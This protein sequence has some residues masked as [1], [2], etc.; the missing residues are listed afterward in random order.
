MPTSPPPTSTPGPTPTPSP[1]P[2]PPSFTLKE[3]TYGAAGTL[4][5]W[6]ILKDNGA[7]AYD[8][9]HWKDT[10]ELRYPY[11]FKA[12]GTV[13]IVKAKWKIENPVEDAT[14]KVEGTGPDGMKF[15]K[16][17]L[18]ASNEEEIEIT[19]VDASQALG[20]AVRFYDTFDISWKISVNDGEDTD[21]GLSQNPIYVCLGPVLVSP[22]LTTVDLACFT[23]GATTAGEAL[24]NTWALLSDGSN[25]PTNFEAWNET[26]Q[27]WTRKL[28]YYKAGTSFGANAV[29]DTA[30]LLQS[31]DSTGQCMT[32]ASLMKDALSLNGVTTIPCVAIPKRNDR[33][34]VKDWEFGASTNPDPSIWNFLFNNSIYDMTPPSTGGIYGDL[35]NSNAR[36][37]QNSAPPS[38]KVF[39]NHVFLKYIPTGT[40]YDPSYGVTY[41]GESDFQTKALDGFGDDATPEN[42]KAKMEVIHPPQSNEVIFSV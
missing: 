14:Y 34:L 31:T 37:G 30:S 11:L 5:G 10:P 29:G 32:W 22:Y 39:A 24:A 6:D 20:N 17:D 1:T 25:R 13:R 23:S 28:Y 15:T 18:K 19:N 12:G 4:Q 40:F 38:Q 35:V 33:F 3:V 42:G 2:E 27:N 41:S 8:G 26:A 9:P 36:P 21:A 7:G 16:S